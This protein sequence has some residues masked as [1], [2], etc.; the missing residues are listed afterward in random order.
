MTTYAVTVTYGNRFH[1]LKQIIESALSEC[2]AKVI[3]VDNNSEPQSKEQLQSYE[4]ELGSDKIK[5]LYLDDNYGSAGGFK[6]GLEEAYSD[7]KSEYILVL[8]DDNLLEKGSFEKLKALNIYLENLNSLF[9]LGF[10][11]DM[12]NADRK[13][14][15]NGWIKKY[16]PNNFIGFNLLEALRYK[17]LKNITD[18][19][20]NLFPLQPAEITAMGGTFF[21]KS[22]L[23]KIGYPNEDFYLYADDHDFTYRFTK[24]GGKIFLCSELKLQDIDFTTVGIGGVE[25][26]YFD[27]E[28][29]EF[30]MYYGV[31]NHTYLSKK[32]IENKIL[33]YGNMS[34]Y[35]FLYL[36]KIF[37]TPKKLFF[38]RY[39]LLL[40]AIKDGLN[41]KL[42]RT[43]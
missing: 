23:E 22:V 16:L 12:W 34:V 1:L 4:K 28:F 6:R 35:L 19:N 13:A 32:F 20:I 17:F 10:Y 15:E 29:S 24:S 25:I 39:S 18:E 41:G 43:F 21:H 31:R 26:G 33:F 9:M 2:V 3:V 14:I 5:V 30:K 27:E 37:K 40:K 8:D 42:G 7:E 38:R 36:K 11:R